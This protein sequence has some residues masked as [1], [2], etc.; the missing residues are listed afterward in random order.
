MTE[1]Q[2]AEPEVINAPEPVDPVLEN[3]LCSLLIARV[4]DYAIF[5]LNPEGMVM[6]WN[7]GAR[8]IKGYTR[9]EIVGQPMTRFYTAEDQESGRPQELLRDA[10]RNGRVEDEG[11]RVRKDGTRFWADVVITAVK[12]DHGQLL[13]FAK[14]TR[15]LTERRKAEAAI[16]ELSGRLFLMQDEE[17]QRLAGQLHDR[18]SV[19]LTAVLGNLYR[20]K[21]HLK[22]GDVVLLKDVDDC[23]ARVEAAS[24]VIRRV[25]G[26]LHPSRLEQSGL[27]DTLRWYANAMSGESLRVRVELPKEPVPMSSEHEIVLFRLVQESLNYVVGRG[28][29]REVVVRLKT[30]GKLVLELAIK[31]SMPHGLQDA[32]STGAGFAGV[33][34]RLRHL[35]GTLKFVSGGDQ[36]IIE[37]QLSQTTV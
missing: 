28:G 10:M 21:A 23:I 35:G 31:G 1:D 13:G 33:R 27:V 11:W 24:D 19:S 22:S 4:R 16:G 37:A 5:M 6:T 29:Q 30:K 3:K 20:V 7:E 2:P 25:A 34:E 14:I 36:S 32:L 18:T 12:D 17:R 26:M 9:N 15:D 8:V